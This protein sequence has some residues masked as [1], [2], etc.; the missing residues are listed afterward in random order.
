MIHL[1]TGL[2]GAGKTLFALGYVRQLAAGRLCYYSGIS[3]LNQEKLAWE[4]IEDPR[5]WWKMPAGSVVVVDEAQRIF[6]PRGNGA[7]VP[8][9]VSKLETHRHEGIDLVFI[10]QHPMLI[11]NNV[12]R[13]AGRHLHLVRQFGLQRSTVHEWMEVNTN[14]DKSRANSVRK[15]FSF[16]K[17]DYALYKSA[18]VHT[19]KARV[20]KRVYFLVL[21]PLLIFALAYGAMRV[22][23]GMTEPEAVTKGKDAVKLPAGLHSINYGGQ[24]SNVVKAKTASEFIAERVP[25]FPGFPHTAPVYHQIPAPKIAPIPVA[26]IVSK[27]KGCICYTQ[28]GTK[29]VDMDQEVCA[30][31]VANGYFVDWELPPDRSGKMSGSLPGDQKMA[32]GSAATKS[33]VGSPMVLVGET[34]LVAA[35]G[36]AGSGGSTRGPALPPS[37]LKK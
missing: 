26:C 19:H 3:D 20:P 30:S 9:F 31:I 32:S 13:L 6:R 37:P 29:I 23:W 5:D 18:E 2:P 4:E 10:T 28:Q 24:A 35:S 16:P 7:A 22:L 17:Q 12:R 1:I 27:S 15:V 36:Y 21:G 34:P 14:C 11:E 8:E 33:E 25:V